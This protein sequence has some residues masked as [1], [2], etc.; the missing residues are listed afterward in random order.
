MSVMKFT[1]TIIKNLL[2]PSVTTS[3]PKEK[4]ES[5]ELTRGHIEVNI[6]NCVYCGL[7]SRKCPT[8][9]IIVNRE[10]NDWEIDRLKCIQCGYCVESCPKK[11]IEMKNEYTKPTKG[12]KV[13]SYFNKS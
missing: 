3:Y 2:S 8:G 7:C 5:Y 4:K 13:D 9:A 6:E 1:K 10:S 11:C 12:E